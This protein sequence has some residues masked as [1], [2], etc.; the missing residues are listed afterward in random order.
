MTDFN[1]NK[2][3]NSLPFLPPKVTLE[4]T[5]VLRKTID[6]SRALAQLNGMLTNL[7]NPTLFL[8]TIHLQEAKASSEIEN[9]ITTNDDLYKS[10]VADKKFDN[11]ATKEVISYK[12]ALWNGLQ[13]IEKR[14]F[15]TTNLCVEIVQSI[16]KNTAGIRTTPRTALKNAKGETIYTPP[17]G[18]SVIREKLANL[19]AFI[20]GED[21]I[22]PLIKMAIMH[23]QFEAIHP[24]SDG[25]G[26]T[27]RILLLL[28]LKLEKLLDTPAIYL[29]E[30]IIK[31]KVDYYT[32]LREVTE[33]EDWEAWIIYML[34]MV[35][36][37]ANKG[38]QRLKVVTNLM[39][40]M[41]TE[42]K[43]TLPKVYTKELVEI[44]FRLP[45]SKR[46]FLIDAKLGTPKTVGNYLNDLEEAGFLISEKV[47]KEKLY[48][49]HRLMTVLEAF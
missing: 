13:L 26:R 19:E 44:L 29:S 2:P 17:T 20:N 36:F 23:Y 48:L 25:N 40:Q 16:K 33:N 28:C 11:P 7:P 34:E 24:F 39:E 41:A 30:Y 45:Y 15:I 12:E 42:I 47:G 49:N 6:A 21:S 27:G 3:Y 38:L 35:E 4:T 14:P 10:L 46:Q 9:I 43:E 5:I 1:R 18:E 22:D 37:T 8:D 32:K 31:N